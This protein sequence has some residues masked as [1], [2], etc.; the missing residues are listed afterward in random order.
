MM[1]NVCFKLKPIGIHT[2][3]EENLTTN[4]YKKDEKGNFVRE[5]KKT[6]EVF[7]YREC[8]KI[9]VLEHKLNEEDTWIHIRTFRK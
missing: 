3:W 7:R 4:G 5:Y 2:N 6:K 1:K 9:I 8:K